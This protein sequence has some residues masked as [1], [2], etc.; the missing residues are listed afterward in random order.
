MAEGSTKLSTSGRRR[1]NK[2][3]RRLAE[4]VD[5]ARV[6]HSPNGLEFVCVGYDRNGNFI[7]GNSDYSLPVSDKVN[8]LHAEFSNTAVE[9]AK[10]AAGLAESDVLQS[11]AEVIIKHH[12]KARHI[13][14]IDWLCSSLNVSR[15]KL[16][17]D[18][19]RQA[20][21]KE[22]SAYREAL[23]QGGLSSKQA[24]EGSERNN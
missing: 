4:K 16:I 17:G 18:M 2:R 19:F 7:G 12:M 8:A 22:A 20:I 3:L 15:D 5:G 10:K 21:M 24:P 14:I 11:A 23:G 9:A 6:I 13:P 1:R